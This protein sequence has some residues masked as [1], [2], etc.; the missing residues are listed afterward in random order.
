METV[1]IFFLVSV[2]FIL[3]ILSAFF[4]GSET[5]MMSLNRYRLRHLA[6]SKKQKAARRVKKLL[7]RP[8]RILGVILIGNTFT[9]I[10][11]SAVAT[12][13]AVHFF[14]NL[15]VIIATIMLTLLILIFAEVTPKTLAALYPERFAFIVSLPLVCLLILLY[16]IVW[17]VN[18]IANA[19][20]GLFGVK[21]TRQ[22]LQQ[23][24]RDELRTL[25]NEAAGKLP[26]KH[27]NMM[28]AVLDLELVSVEDIMVPRNEIIGIDLAEDIDDILMQLRTVQHTR[29]PVYTQEIN[30]VQ[31][32]LHMRKA[33]NVLAKET[34][35]KQDLQEAMED[36]YFVPEN[37]PLSTLLRNFQREKVR[38]GLVVDEYGEM[39]GLVTLEDVLEEI[40]G[41]FTTDL[42]EAYREIHKQA[43]GG[44]VIDGGIQL[45]KLNRI[46]HL[47][48]STQGPKTLS[49]A[50]IEA[51]EMI[52]NPATCLRLDGYRIEILQVKDNTVKTARLLISPSN[53]SHTQPNLT[54]K[55]TSG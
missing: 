19:F 40:V 9:N 35:D 31:G 11:A 38:S 45:R 28:L 46:L 43:D 13:V 44:Y 26:V 50:I 18:L 49:G 47:H 51:L 41:E 22:E 30:H 14:G 2:L 16:P 32:M 21:I 4:S 54:S 34:P 48:F 1:P 29:L 39:L 53:N 20:L 8:D 36:A 25:V 52:P 55:T 42:A 3:I 23:L 33:L 17:L 37:I 7:E 24:S 15:G 10:L 12:V 5:G 27:Q 6:R